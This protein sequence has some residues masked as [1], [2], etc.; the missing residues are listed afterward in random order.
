ML[1]ACVICALSGVLS[2]TALAQSQ[3]QQ[4]SERSGQA[5]SADQQANRQASGQQTSRLNP[6]ALYS[7]W[8]VRALAGQQVSGQN[9]RSMGSLHD[10][11]VDTSGRAAAIVVEGGGVAGVPDTVYR[12]PWQSVSIGSDGISVSSAGPNPDYGTM[13]G[14][15]G[16][17]TWP[18]EYRLSEV[19]GDNARLR[20]G[21]LY[22]YVTDV[23]L[24]NNGR[25]AAVLVAPDAGGDE[26]A[27]VAFPFHGRI[28]RWDPGSSYFGLPFVTPKQARQAGLEVEPSRFAH[29]GG[30]T[31]SGQQSRELGISPPNPSMRDDTA[32]DNSPMQQQRSQTRQRRSEGSPAQQSGQRSDSGSQMAAA[33]LEGQVQ[34]S[35]R[36]LVSPEAVNMRLPE[37]SSLYKGRRVRSL[38]DETVYGADGNELGE[39][40]DI[41]ANARG[42]ITAIVVE[43]GG[44]LDI[45]DAHFRIPWQDVDATPGQDGIKVNLT[46][47]QATQRGLF[48]SGEVV[49]VGEREFRLSEL[50]N[51]YAVLQNGY[52]YGYVDDA[53]IDEQGKLVAVLVGRDI[54]YGP[55]YY[56]Y[57]YY[58]YRYGWHPG[59]AHFAIPF[60]TAQDAS[61][62]TQV[63]KKRFAD[64]RQEARQQ[65]GGTG[66]ETDSS[67]NTSQ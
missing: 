53:V 44:F 63:D 14:Q 18:R 3:Q 62:G 16:V 61:R 57:P 23:V 5:P 19:I 20:T 32:D 21:Q 37:L 50:L 45:G 58:G 36:L 65:G 22:G 38:M 42:Q 54:R 4:S 40:H 46:S 56:A 2:T 64:A 51:D 27:T 1:R 34:R 9:G 30:G 11:I 17:A 10:V 13:S 49:S 31:S 8:R 60:A 24:S 48:D 41:I 43:G 15:Q 26:R 55:G 59:D 66:S 29:A 47:D 52:G 25:V 35:D 33:R 12:I 6:D 39:V 28:G 67:G 7:G